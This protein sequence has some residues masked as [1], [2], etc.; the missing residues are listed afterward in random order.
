MASFLPFD[1]ELDAKAKAHFGKQHLFQP[2]GFQ[3]DPSSPFYSTPEALLASKTAWDKAMDVDE[4][5]RGKFLQDF[6]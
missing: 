1:A 5:K 2:E 6:F 3:P 4:S